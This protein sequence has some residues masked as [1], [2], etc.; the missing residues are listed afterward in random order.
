MCLKINWEKTI[1]LYLVC[2]GS[3]VSFPKQI[4]AKCTII[5]PTTVDRAL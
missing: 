3:S 4:L 1:Q 2:E 5:K